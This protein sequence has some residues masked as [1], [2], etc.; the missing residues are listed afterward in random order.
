[1]IKNP[2]CLQRLKDKFVQNEIEY[3]IPLMKADRCF[4]AKMKPEGIWVS[5]L[6]TSP[7]LNWA[8]FDCA[9]SLG[10]EKGLANGYPRVMQCKGV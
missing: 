4:I 2:D 6:D 3:K 7:M 1:M 9:I 5:N 8:V 10:K